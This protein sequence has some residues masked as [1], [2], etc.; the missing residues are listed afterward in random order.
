MAK[1][2]ECVELTNDNNYYDSNDHAQY[3]HHLQLVFN[4]PWNSLI[5]LYQ[6]P[7]T[8]SFFGPLWSDYNM[9]SYKRV[10]EWCNENVKA[11]FKLIQQTLKLVTAV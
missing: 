5:V 2:P 8:G 7:Q 9:A 10:E 11:A 3:Y 1:H 4:K 6:P